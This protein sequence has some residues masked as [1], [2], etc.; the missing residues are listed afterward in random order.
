MNDSLNILALDTAFGEISAAVL[1]NGEPFLSRP[2][3]SDHGKTRSTTIVPILA[4]LLA[5]AGLS[6]EKLDLLALGA[7]PGA[8]TGLRIAAATLAG[9]NSEMK[10]PILH[11]SSLA[12]TARQA[13]TSEPLWVIEDARAGEAFAGR[14]AA[15]QSLSADRC[16]SWQDVAAFESS[17]FVCHND[18]AID[19]QAWKRLELLIPRS[20]ALLSEAEQVLSDSVIKQLPVYPDPVYLQRSQAEKNLHV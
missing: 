11:L 14:Y 6:W 13:I 16:I 7:G 3:H 12:I 18:P 9:I 19:M 17:R 4:D 2:N 20:A 1:C 8:F 10:L 15:G 5:Q